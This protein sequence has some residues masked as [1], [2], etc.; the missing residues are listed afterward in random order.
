M[1]HLDAIPYFL[2]VAEH[3]SFAE[4]ARHL[5]VSR[6]AVSKRVNQLETTL[7]VRLLHRTTR[8]VSLTEAGSHYFT[9]AQN[10]YYWIQQAEDAATS[11]QQSPIGK[12]RICVPMS[13][14]RLK[15]A[16][17][18]PG[19]LKKYPL[20]EIDMVMDDRYSDIVAAG[21]DVAIR[22]G[23]LADSSLIARKLMSSRSLICTSSAY[24]DGKPLP[25]TPIDLTEH[26]ALIYSYSAQTTEWVFEYKDHIETVAVRG[27][28]R[29]NNSEALLAGCL[30]GVGVGRL[31]DFIAKPYIDN[32]E[33]IQLLPE[34]KMPEKN[35]WAVFPER[36]YM[37]VK[38]RAFIDYL[39]E[40]LTV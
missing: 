15:I 2:A 31:P 40:V 33:L 30:Q 39:S 23:E 20:V 27:N 26:N 14:G 16:P 38:V 18:I 37:P 10:A 35:I 17:L 22:G 13:F 24:L 9:N 6:S 28:Y 8:K 32:G 36:A 21:F 5:D 7:G 12:L 1:E 11:R 25:K 19:F 34:Y 4:A 3:E 29:V